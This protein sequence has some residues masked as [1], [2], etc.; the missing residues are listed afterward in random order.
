MQKQTLF[1]SFNLFFVTLFAFFSTSCSTPCGEDIDTSDIKID[2]NFSL[3]HKD[4]L[5]AA[6]PSELREL[7][8][9]DS[10]LAHAYFGV[11]EYPD[12]SMLFKGMHSVLQNEEFQVV[13]NEAERVFGEMADIKIEFEDAFRRIKYFYPDFEAPRIV[14]TI[15]GFG[16]GFDFY[17]SDKLI[18]IGLDYFIGETASFRPR[19]IPMYILERYEK[20][21]IVPLTVKFISGAY[22][23]ND[24]NEASMLHDMI[25]YGK[26]LYFTSQV[27]PCADEHL[28][29]GYKE[30][31]VE[32]TRENEIV[33]W[34]HFLENDLVYETS[35]MKKRKYLEERPNIPEIGDKCPGRVGRWLG[36]RMVK[37]YAEREKVSLQEVMREADFEKIYTK[38]RYRPDR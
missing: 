29:V 4:M 35:E 37:L 24:P 31:V 18:V 38:S 5:S 20:E 15:T 28:L 30:E 26:A 23:Y 17:V 33:I 10:L 1:L 19:H 9:S 13:V 21:N 22:N 8:M 11:H 12:D 32:E 25:Y 34:A 36:Y 2:I 7:I 3:F 27:L 6:S 14:T 16:E